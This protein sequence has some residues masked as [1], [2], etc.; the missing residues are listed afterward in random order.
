MDAVVWFDN[1]FVPWERVFL[2]RDLEAAEPVFARSRASHGM[3]QTNT[4]N[5]AK[6]EFL[7]GIAL[8]VAERT[9]R[10]ASRRFR[11]PRRDDHTALK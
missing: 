2:Y 5:L 1:V 8:A 10:I 7:L 9:V 4:K 3:H 6:A 11:P